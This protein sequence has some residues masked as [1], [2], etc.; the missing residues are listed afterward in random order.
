MTSQILIV[1][2]DILQRQMLET[3]MLRKLGFVSHLAEHGRAALEILS[4]DKDGLIKLV[5][6]DMS[7]PVMGGLET[8]EIISQ[9]YP[10]LP[11][12]MLTGS[13]NLDDAIQAMKIG[14]IDFV[15]KPFESERMIITIRN[16]LKITTLSK[17][18]SRLQ[19]DKDGRLTFSN[20]IGADSGLSEVVAIGR[21][22]AA[23]S[24]PVLITGETG[25]GKEVFAKAIHGESQRAG[26]P[27]IAVNCGA[28]P[29]QLL[30]SILFGH[31]KGAFTGATEKAIGKFREADGGTIFLDEIGELPKDAQVKLLRVLQQKEVEPVG[32][33]RSVPVNIR[34]ISATNRDLEAEVKAGNFREDLFFRLNVLHIHL[35]PLR[36]RP[37]DVQVLA[38]HFIE[39]FCAREAVSPKAIAPSFLSAMKTHDWPGNVRELENVINRSM[40]MSDDKLLD[41]ESFES[42]YA[43]SSGSSSL[44]LTANR[45]GDNHSLD[46]IGLSGDFKTMEELEREIILHVLQHFDNNVTKT[47]KTL[48]MAKSTLYK[49][50]AIESE[51]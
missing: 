50:L 44:A 14:A 39:R 27:F 37:E 15:N 31:E 10:G 30:E 2:D 22:A 41:F 6:M 9:K 24:I 11:V 40:V 51:P 23:S 49:K 8:L 7:M 42:V 29:A 12:I 46:L 28:I 36:K 19:N 4:K 32:A 47:A 3:L 45:A 5:I 38:N 33:A 20:L 34:I 25:T 18:I 1:E 21:K 48:S 17:E 43:R 35:P 13:T 26:K 16:A